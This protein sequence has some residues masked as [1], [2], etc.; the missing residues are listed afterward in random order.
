MS[1]LT[2]TELE[3]MQNS[4]AAA[5]YIVESLFSSVFEL[6]G[7]AEVRIS[8]SIKKG[9][10]HIWTDANYRIVTNRLFDWWTQNMPYIYLA[11]LEDKTFTS[12]LYDGLV[13]VADCDHAKRLDAYAY[14]EDGSVRKSELAED[15]IFHVDFTNFNDALYKKLLTDLEKS[16]HSLDAISDR[17]D[18]FANNLTPAKRQQISYIACNFMYLF[19]ELMHNNALYNWMEAISRYYQEMVPAH[20][21]AYDEAADNPE[22]FA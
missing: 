12:R 14:N 10:P 21:A 7:T 17:I 15:A 22:D 1:N 18:D 11:M 6:D 8:E 13:K 2:N 20:A 19:F 9:C 4:E 16:M 5:A 3:S